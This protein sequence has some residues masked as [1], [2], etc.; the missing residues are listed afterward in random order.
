MT[1]TTNPQP[2]ARSLPPW[3]ARLLA[4]AVALLRRVQVQR[5]DKS[6]RVCETLSLGDKRFLAIVQLEGRRLLIGA[7]AQ[8]ISLLERL[9]SGAAHAHQCHSSFET[10]RLNGVR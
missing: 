5:R 4:A 7:T 6:L 2:T 3:C 10:Q 9:D 1:T 8:S